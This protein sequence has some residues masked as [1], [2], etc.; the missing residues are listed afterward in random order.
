M[1]HQQLPQDPREPHL[2]IVTNASK[3]EDMKCVLVVSKLIIKKVLTQGAPM[4]CGYALHPSAVDET[5]KALLSEEN[6]P[7]HCVFDMV[8][9]KRNGGSAVHTV[10]GTRYCLFFPSFYFLPVCLLS[11]HLTYVVFGWVQQSWS[12]PSHILMSWQQARL[13][14]QGF[15][16]MAM[17][18]APTCVRCSGAFVWD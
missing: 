17:P 13:E 12:G 7:E 1:H 11:N 18:R 6:W 9:G 16:A 15:L 4:P 2:P 5:I 14:C 3:V 10:T 8:K